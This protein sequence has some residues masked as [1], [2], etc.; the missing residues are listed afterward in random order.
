MDDHDQI[1]KY[2]AEYV[3]R[4][5]RRIFEE[6]R[7]IAA[8]KIYG[9]QAYR[10]DGTPRSRSGRLQQALASP[11][12]SITGSGSSISAKAQYPT[13]LRFLDMK[14]LGNYRIYNRTVWGILYKETFNDIRFEFSAW[15][16]KNLADSIRESY[17]QS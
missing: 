8:A 10:T 16:R 15:L 12:F 5:F 11:T 2:F 14:R 13:Y 6:Q 3:N 4:G 7:R 1:A 9:K 17:Q